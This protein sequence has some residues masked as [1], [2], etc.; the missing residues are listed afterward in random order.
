M[1]NIAILTETAADGTTVH[2][3]NFEGREALLT[4]PAGNTGKWMM[5]T[6]YHHAF[7]ATQDAA[8]AR[9]WGMGWLQ[10]HNRW[11]TDDDLDARAR[12]IDYVSARFGLDPYIVPIGMS[13]GGLIA[14]NFAS[15][16]PTYVS[17]L[18]LDAPLLNLLSF[19]L[20]LGKATPEPWVWEKE[21]VPIF[22][23]TKSEVLVWRNQPMDRL[24]PL[25][26]HRIPVALVAGDSDHVVPYEENGLVLAKRYAETDIPI[27]IWIKPGCDHHPHGLDNPDEVLAYI[28]Q[29]AR[30]DAARVT[31]V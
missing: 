26:A 15:K 12:F 28:E 22:G 31:A 9:G 13:C 19:P 1:E 14:V 10:N 3:F 4:I 11:G 17:A 8:V 23:F 27:R 5:K 2:R 24:D 6:E 7:P 21:I 20:G 18:Y 30:P 25:I 16:Y 29:V